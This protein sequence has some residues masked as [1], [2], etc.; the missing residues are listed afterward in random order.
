[1]YRFLMICLLVVAGWGQPLLAAPPDELPP[2]PSP[3][4]FV[5]DQAQLLSPADA[6]T[7]ERGLRRYADNTGTQIVVVT[8]PTLGSRSI[9]DY[10]RDLGEA[11]GIGQRTQNNGVV[12]LLAGQE[13]QVSIQAG[14][15]LRQQITPELTQRVIGQQ[16]TPEFKQGRY[17][18]GLRAG[19]NQL[20]LAAN[21]ES[22][23]RREQPDAA[24]AAGSTAPLSSNPGL[25]ADAGAGSGSLQTPPPSYGNEPFSP[26]NQPAAAPASPGLGMGSMLL[27]ALVLGGGIWLLLRRFRRKQ[28]PATAQGPVPDF[29]PNRPAGPNGGYG[30]GGGYGATGGYSQAGNYGRAPMHQPA[31]DFYPNR[32]GGMSS[33]MGGALLTGAAAAAGAYLGNRMASA[34]DHHHDSAGNDLGAGSAPPL[35]TAPATGAAGGGFAALGGAGGANDLGP[36]AAPDYFSDEALQDNSADYFANDDASAYDDL[37]SDDTGG[38]GFDDTNDNSGSW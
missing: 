1:M 9:A 35:P 15:G 6:N 11:W 31:P 23:P 22:A 32:G 12:V 28:T 33:G 3:F 16:M 20:M 18:A 24:A 10:A 27:G 38:G 14:S 30:T 8:V 4:K 17:F 21:P 13:R 5:T 19:L 36:D 7:L 29:Y 25:G 26:N 37:S 2:R 34:H